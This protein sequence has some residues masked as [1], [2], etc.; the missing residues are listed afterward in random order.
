MERNPGGLAFTIA[1]KAKNS[2]DQ[3]FRM[4]KNITPIKFVRE[5][6]EASETYTVNAAMIFKDLVAIEEG[7]Q[8]KDA[9][10]S[11]TNYL[12][13]YTNGSMYMYSDS[14]ENLYIGANPYTNKY[15]KYHTIQ[16]TAYSNN[17]MCSSVNEDNP[18]NSPYSAYVACASAN[19]GCTID[20]YVYNSNGT[21]YGYRL[22]VGYSG[23][24]SF[25]FRNKHIATVTVG[26]SAPSGSG[27]Q[28][29]IHVVY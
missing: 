5:G 11:K 27:I 3:I 18:L 10:F 2:I 16:S 26:S 29:Q 23:E 15:G 22:Y 4:L 28:G 19:T 7:I 21:A 9:T 14:Y 6:L 24:P 12:K 1:S 20:N 13:T 8:V 25:T 17:I